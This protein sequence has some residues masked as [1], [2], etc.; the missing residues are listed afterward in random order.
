MRSISA[1]VAE[2]QGENMP[3]KQA[4]SQSLDHKQV[5]ATAAAATAVE[6]PVEHCG[7]AGEQGLPGWDREIVV[8]H[9]RM[10]LR[11]RVRCR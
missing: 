8:R 3:T 4:A 11:S 6:A 2:L 1:H 9:G 7:C 10:A 5:I